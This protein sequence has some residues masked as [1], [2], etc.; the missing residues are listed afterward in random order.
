[1]I[2]FMLS[3]P[4]QADGRE[5]PD[6]IWILVTRPQVDLTVGDTLEFTVHVFDEGE[7]IEVD[8]IEV[9]ASQYDTEYELVDLVQLGRGMWNGSV[10]LVD[11]MDDGNYTYIDV[12]LTIDGAEYWHFEFFEWQ[13][14][15]YSERLILTHDIVPRSQYIDEDSVRTITW[16]VRYGGQLVDPDSMDIWVSSED[17]GSWYLPEPERVSKGVYRSVIYFAE[18]ASWNWEHRSEVYT[19]VFDVDYNTGYYSFN[20]TIDDRIPFYLNYLHVW[21]QVTSPPDAAPSR[22]ARS[23]SHPIDKPTMKPAQ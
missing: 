14:S 22:A 21:G 4:V 1:M 8:I 9:Y 12:N 13:M 11:S 19:V 23:T 18:N 3:A 17:Y 20:E 6:A 2:L 7:Y 5:H 10:H 15:H 16:E